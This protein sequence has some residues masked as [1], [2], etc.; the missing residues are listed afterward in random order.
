VVAVEG[1]AGVRGSSSVQDGGGMGQQMMTRIGW[2]MQKMMTSMRAAAQQI[3]PS[4]AGT[5]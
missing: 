3:T 2:K 4:A 5:G 1:S